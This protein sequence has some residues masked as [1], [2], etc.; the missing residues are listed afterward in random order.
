M[1]KFAIGLVAT[2][3]TS[4]AAMGAPIQEKPVN[5]VMVVHMPAANDFTAVVRNGAE[6]AAKQ[7]GVHLQFL[8]NETFD[9]VWM[10]QTLAEVVGKRPDGIA[11]TLP[12]AAALGDS[13]KLAVNAGIPV[14]V[15]NGGVRDF[16][17][18]GA[19]SYVGQDNYEAGVG[20]GKRLKAAG[21]THGVCVNNQVGNVDLDD[22][23]R[24][25]ADGFGGPTEVL[26]TNEDPVEM[27]DAFAAYLN[28]HPQVDAMLGVW[29]GRV[30]SIVDGAK[31]A[32]RLGKLRIG[33]FDLSDSALKDIGDGTVLFCIDQQQFLQGY[34]PIVL[35]ANKIRYGL[36]PAT[37]VIS[38]GPAFV[39]N[40]TAAAVV[41]LVKQG[42]R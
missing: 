8:S 24:G 31:M 27:R 40:D 37:K 28:K 26:G 5:I 22:R 17:K 20:A 13:I 29:A 7:M 11:T 33:E 25:F 18:L 23:C 12:D 41:E 14:V 34:L 10:N 4:A 1:R 30:D 2:V 15:F 3:L 21:G 36:L 35:L 38:S 32:D 16:E 42:V 9:M 6:L 19:L 39:T